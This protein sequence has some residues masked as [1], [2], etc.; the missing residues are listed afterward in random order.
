MSWIPIFVSPRL[1]SKND[2]LLY[3]LE[4]NVS[5]S[6]QCNG[7]LQNTDTLRL[8]LVRGDSQSYGTLFS[9]VLSACLHWNVWLHQMSFETFLMLPIGTPSFPFFLL[10][11]GMFHVFH[12]N[13]WETSKMFHVASDAIHTFQWKQARREVSQKR[14]MPFFFLRKLCKQI[15]QA[16]AVMKE[17]QGLGAFHR[18][19]VPRKK[20]VMVIVDYL[21]L[22]SFVIYFYYYL[23]LLRSYYIFLTLGFPHCCRNHYRRLFIVFPEV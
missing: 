16:F 9:N 22:S 10:A 15:S 18:S 21:S 8:L 13:V 17:V 19:C 3:M 7:I 5:A 20:K 14:A 1:K 6:L 2:N 12:V 11:N 23:L 4:N